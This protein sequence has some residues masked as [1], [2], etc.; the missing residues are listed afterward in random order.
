[1]TPRVDESR[2]VGE[3]LDTFAR[4]R[5]W[6]GYVSRLL[7]RYIRGDVLEV[8]AGI[9][10][11]T[12]ALWTSTATSWLCLEPDAAL[13]ARLAGL[14]LGARAVTPE[15]VVGDLTAIAPERRFDTILYIDVL[16]HI[17]DDRGELVRA[18]R[19]L[20]PGGRI[21]VLSPAFQW[22]FS[23][24]DRAIGHERRYTART[25]AAVAPPACPRE[26]LFYADSVGLLTSAVNRVLLRRSLPTVQQVLLWDRVLVPLSRV[27]DPLVRRWVGRSVIGVF[28]RSA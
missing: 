11:T 25:L 20:A 10:T 19:H 22:A 26:R 23:A 14:Q 17:A 5:N 9:G 16:E 2:Y 4:A 13:A 18:A 21:V 8:G 24:F 7:D 27:V 3:E 28:R 12:R 1:M 6:K 15:V